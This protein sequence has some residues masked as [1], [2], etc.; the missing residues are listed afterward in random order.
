M[1]KKFRIGVLLLILAAVALD[2]WRA[3]AQLDWQLPFHVVL[4][5]INAD[6]STRVAAY[7]KT[8]KP[9][10]FQPVTDYFSTEAKRYQLPLSRPISI[11]LG[12]TI[13]TIPPAPPRDGNLLG[14][15]SWSLKFRY[16]SWQHSPTP[17]L[18]PEIRLYLLYYDPA[19]QPRLSH[20]TALEKGRIGRVNLFGTAKQ[21]EQN[22]MVLAHE[23][24]HTVGATDKYDFSTG[25]PLYPIG[26]ADPVQQPRYPQQRAE[27][28]GGRVPLSADKADIPRNLNQTTVS[29]LTAR[30]IGWLK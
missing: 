19:V 6:G 1:W 12:Q 4:Y 16:Y 3:K 10:D 20:S 18:K 21:H 23:L 28:M 30:E 22:L 29:A 24:L 15:I 9:Q 2:T 26:Y 11:Q 17:S 5:P 13:H 14:V 27:L 8:L 25:L 7:L